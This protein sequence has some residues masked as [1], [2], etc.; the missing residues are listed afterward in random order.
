[1]MYANQLAVAI[2]SAGKVLREFNRDHVY[3][4][5]GAEYSVFIRNLD[6][7]RRVLA[8]L[9]I[10]GKDI[11]DGTR[12]VVPAGGSIDLERYVR[13]GNFLEGNRFKFIERTPG[14]ENHRGVGVEDGLI[15][16]EYNFEQRA[17]EIQWVPR[18]RYYYDDWQPARIYYGNVHNTLG[19]AVGSSDTF[20]KSS[21]GL[22]IA[23][24]SESYDADASYDGDTGHKLA[25][26]PRSKSADSVKMKSSGRGIS[27]ASASLNASPA[28]AN[29]S[30]NVNQVLLN[31]VSANAA[32]QNDA[33]ITVDGSV[34]N[35]QFHHSYGFP[36][37]ST[38]FS[39][40]LKL[41]GQTEKGQEVVQAVTVQRKIKCTT[42]GTLNKGT[43]KFCTDCGAS[44]IHL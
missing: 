32:P 41:L 8:R 29:Y 21:G 19:G 13:N 20:T 12:F 28:S 1:M 17:P 22:G 14:V 27:G 35:Q 7:S 26:V 36:T 34:S 31:Q 4:P 16:V 5:F 43:A 18:T 30:A 39:I 23:P 25:S 6:P 42:C 33:G 38:T 2:K 10:D 3:L 11:G 24:S 40:V 44:M 37:D 15:S 9:L